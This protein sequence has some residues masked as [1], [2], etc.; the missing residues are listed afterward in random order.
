MLAL[1]GFFSMQEVAI[2]SYDPLLLNYQ[3]YKKD[4]RAQ[5]VYRFIRSPQALF[6][7]TLVVIE[8][9]L[10]F[11]SECFR[12]AFEGLGVPVHLVPFLYIPIV[13]VF[14]ELVPLFL[15]RRFPHHIARFGVVFLVPLQY[16]ILP[17]SY[18]MEKVIKCIFHVLRVKGREDERV[19]LQ[20][21][22]I[23]LALRENSQLIQ[24][25]SSQGILR[26]ET[27]TFAQ[28]RKME[29]KALAKSL[30]NIPFLFGKMYSAEIAKK[31]F[32]VTSAPF[33]LCF[34]PSERAP[35][36]L[37]PAQ[38]LLGLP[39]EGVAF[40]D[41][42]KS[43]IILGSYNPFST[44]FELSHFLKQKTPFFLIS[45]RQDKIVGWSSLKNFFE[46]F[47]G[48]VS[49]RYRESGAYSVEKTISGSMQVNQ[50]QREF[51]I[52][53][54]EAKQES[55]LNELLQERLG[56]APKMGDSYYFEHSRIELTV[57]EMSKSL[58]AKTIFLRCI[59]VD[60]KH[61]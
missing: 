37:F 36:F 52:S 25:M 15:G 22:D 20:R 57:I 43:R 1:E 33:L 40:D 29:M 5:A 2:V 24:V 34:S 10:H 6:T 26:F 42:E 17:F 39:S 35:R 44:S 3:I 51:S 48:D 46:E 56:R 49:T 31:L 11:G 28:L 41:L 27:K 7:T 19:L 13:V 50:L 32:K 30:H 4:V 55:T 59:E 38:A 14:A 16:L 8:F 21:E 12:N 53:I 61:S 60:R 45:D 54:L 23:L 9:A 47:F 18:L 58:G